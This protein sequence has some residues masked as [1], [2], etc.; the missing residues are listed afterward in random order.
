MYKPFSDIE[1]YTS[2]DYDS[3]EKR[4]D[5]SLTIT[6]IFHL[7]VFTKTLA[8]VGRFLKAYSNL[9]ELKRKIS[10]FSKY[11]VAGIYGAEY[12]REGSYSEEDIQTS[13]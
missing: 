5:F 12:Q 8:Q 13:A 3:R 10:E 6:L 1:Q 4:N 2:E 11:E 9:T 7:E